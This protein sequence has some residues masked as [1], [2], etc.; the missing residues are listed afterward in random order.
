VIPYP[1]AS[2]CLATVAAFV[3]ARCLP[4]HRPVAWGLAGLAA[5]SAVALACAGAPRGSGTWWGHVAAMLGWY[6]GSAAL[7]LSAMRC[8]VEP[9]TDA[10]L[11][12]GAS[13]MSF[14]HDRPPHLSIV[15]P[16]VWLASTLAQLAAVAWA[17]PGIVRAR[18]VTSGQA[19][20]LLVCASSC[21]DVVTWTRA[22]VA[23]SWGL[24]QMPSVATWG[25]VALV[26]G[27]YWIEAR[28]R[29]C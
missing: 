10:G 11:F 17:L 16:W 14:A 12:V 2:L 20:A 9:W 22:D 4:A 7:V 25:A 1:L 5:C 29:R 13:L 18:R 23:G 27:W 15:W 8:T 3:L 19:V 26:Q 24:T 28:P 21:A 6:A